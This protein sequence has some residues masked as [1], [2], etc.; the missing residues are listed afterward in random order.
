LKTGEVLKLDFTPLPHNQNFEL[1][2]HRPYIDEIKF[3]CSCGGEF[4]RISDVFD[5]W[6][7]SGSM[8]YASVHYPF[9]LA[10]IQNSKFK[11]Q[12]LGSLLK[13]FSFPAEFIAE[14]IDQTRGWFYTLLVLSAALFNKPAF[15]NVIVNGIILAEDGQKMSKRLKNYPGPMDLVKKYGADALRLYLLSS[16]AVKAE[17]LN[18]SEKGVEEIYRKVIM[19]L[20]NVYQFYDLY[21]DKQ[22]QSSKFKGQKFNVLD[23]WILAM[24]NQLNNEVSKAMDSYELDRAVKPIINF[25][26]DFSTWYVRRSRRRFQ[27]PENK[28]EFRNASAVFGF[29]LTEFAKVI[30]PFLPFISEAI[31]QQIA[32]RESQSVH[33]E[34]WPTINSKFKIQNSKL[35]KDMAGIRRLA[36]LAL[37]KRAESGIKVRQPLS[38]LRIKNYELRNNEELLKILAD[39]I[40][41]KKIVFDGKIK[42]EVELDTK[43]TAELR[44]EGILR[45]FIRLVQGLRQ[46]AGYK[47]KDVIYLFVSAGD[48]DAVLNKNLNLLKKEVGAKNIEFRRTDKFD[49]G[50]E[51]KIDGSKIWIGIKKYEMGKIY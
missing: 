42:E 39:E 12:N 33:L 15:K 16:P 26:D 45:E 23:Q 4:K 31:Y 20:W 44:E 21:T 47:P 5:C 28:K 49:A 50:E 41:V 32:K 14:G 29:I 13:K 37:A 1:D 24:F 8:P 2:F 18:F 43:I 34:N 51:T 25:V 30:S 6:F 48:L 38:E 17:N 46:E 11:I 19:R 40:N 22:V 3:P 35:I 36:S 10:Q 27:K 9:A 7:E